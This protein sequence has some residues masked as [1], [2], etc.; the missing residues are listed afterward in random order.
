MINYTEY[1]KEQLKDCKWIN[2]PSTKINWFKENKYSLLLILVLFL[3]VVINYFI[4]KY[5]K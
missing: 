5:I 4:C 3:I 2:H 1:L